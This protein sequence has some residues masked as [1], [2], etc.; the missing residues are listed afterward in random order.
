MTNPRPEDP[1]QD[2]KAIRAHAAAEIHRLTAENARLKA[3]NM[4]LRAVP[5][6]AERDRLREEL[7]QFKA[8]TVDL[9][10]AAVSLAERM[11]AHLSPQDCEMV[12]GLRKIID[13]MGKM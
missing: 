7:D 10:D 2:R 9:G 13:A 6:I 11:H 12:K 4:R 5:I 1:V 8:A 3:E